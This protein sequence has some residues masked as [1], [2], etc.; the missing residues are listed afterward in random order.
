MITFAMRPVYKTVLVEAKLLLR[1][2]Q[3]VFFTLV[4][5]LLLLF[6]LGNIFLDS[7][8]DA[9]GGRQAVGVLVTG[10]MGLIVTTTGLSTMPTTIAAYRERGILRRLGATPVRP[11]TVVGAQI[12]VQ[13]GL[14]VVGLV[15]LLGA[16]VLA[17]GL[18]LPPVPLAVV[19]GLVLGSLSMFGLGFVIAAVVPTLRAAQALAS[20]LLFPML[21]LS[22]ATIPRAEMPEHVRTVGDFLP[23]THMITLTQD[24]WFDQSWNMVSVAVLVGVLVAGVAAGTR[25][26][27]WE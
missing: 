4:F 27:R 26:F 24:L 6:L 11:S 15:L 10:F 7:S 21:F 16:G 18:K 20:V 9:I 25:L 22:G 23:L 5:P 8:D 1:E 17:Y 13:L 3:T 2:R 12:V 14:A 19:P